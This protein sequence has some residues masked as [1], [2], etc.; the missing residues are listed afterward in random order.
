M[1]IFAA[2]MKSK[3]LIS[4]FLFLVLSIQVLPLQRIAAWLSSGQ[5]TEEIA[6]SPNLTKGKSAL[7]EADHSFLLA[8]FHSGARSPFLSSM[9]KHHRDVALFTR[10]ADEILTPPPNESLFPL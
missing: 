7:D 9:K 10:H 4:L 5:I 8:S 6:H 2:F 1:T 3:K